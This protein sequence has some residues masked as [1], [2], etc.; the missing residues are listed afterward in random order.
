M[1]FKR[2]TKEAALKKFNELLE[3]VESFKDGTLQIIKSFDGYYY[4]EDG[5]PFLRTGES[6]IKEETN[7]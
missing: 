7:L 4:V 3:N 6:V 2:K 1:L 5:L